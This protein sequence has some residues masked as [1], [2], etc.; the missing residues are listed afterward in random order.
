[1]KVEKIVSITL[2]EEEVKDAIVNW[3]N[4]TLVGK[5]GP[6]LLNHIKN[7]YFCIDCAN[8]E[9]IL[10]VDGVYESEID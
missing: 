2:T 10:S 3:L 6:K 5:N 7:N 9:F 4:V 1:M 8:G